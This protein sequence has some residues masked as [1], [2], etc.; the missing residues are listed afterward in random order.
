[1]WKYWVGCLRSQH[2]AITS[3]RGQSFWNPR[4]QHFSP[5]LLATLWSL[6]SWILVSHCLLLVSMSQPVCLSQLLISY[7]MVHPF[8][9]STYYLHFWINPLFFFS[10]SFPPS[11]LSC[12]SGKSLDRLQTLLQPGWVLEVG[13]FQPYHIIASLCFVPAL[14]LLSQ[15]L[16]SWGQGPGV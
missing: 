2:I 13:E 8:L 3:R 10:S 14:S 12:L 7:Y 15:M 6:S 4:S 1:M 9:V 11:F 5:S 16:S